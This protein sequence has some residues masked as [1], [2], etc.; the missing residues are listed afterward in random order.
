MLTTALAS[1][2]YPK[3]SKQINATMKNVFEPV[4]FIG[5]K[6]EQDTFRIYLMQNNQG[7]TNQSASAEVEKTKVKRITC[8]NEGKIQL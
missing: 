4:M 7:D 1:V 6:K 2:F 5:F 8:I 3:A